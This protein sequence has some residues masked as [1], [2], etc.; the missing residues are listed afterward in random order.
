MGFN[1]LEK[2]FVD[3]R[4]FI[5]IKQ[6]SLFISTQVSGIFYITT[7]NI[8]YRYVKNFMGFECNYGLLAVM[9]K[10][11]TVSPYSCLDSGTL[12]I[13]RFIA[14]LGLQ[15]QSP[16]HS[17]AMALSLP[18]LEILLELLQ[19]RLSPSCYPSQPSCR[20]R[21][22]S[23]GHGFLFFFF[24]NSNRRIVTLDTL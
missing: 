19:L 8:N 1:L 14:G 13:W 11:R 6:N 24:W 23:H 10:D 12:F 17:Q 5:N 3:H 22:R 21:L 20:F 15:L 9:F 7:K 2:F 4:F 16:D 18:K